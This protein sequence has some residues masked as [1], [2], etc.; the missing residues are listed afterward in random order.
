[1]L[2]HIY[3]GTKSFVITKSAILLAPNEYRVSD[4]MQWLNLDGE[5]EIVQVHIQYNIVYDPQ[6]RWGKESV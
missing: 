1:M 5:H 6:L 3:T 4:Y 2:E